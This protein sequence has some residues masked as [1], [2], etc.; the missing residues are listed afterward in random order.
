VDSPGRKAGLTPSYA[1]DVMPSGDD[2]LVGNVGN[3]RMRGGSGDDVLRGGAGKDEL[4][5]VP[6]FDRCDAGTGRYEFHGCEI[7]IATVS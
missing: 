3:D 5:G 7:R 1:A 6:G 4:F 2:R